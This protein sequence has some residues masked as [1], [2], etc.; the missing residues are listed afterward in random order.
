[1]SSKSKV[2]RFQLLMLRLQPTFLILVSISLTKKRFKKHSNMNI[3]L[4]C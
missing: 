2:I 4:K 1:M 3:C